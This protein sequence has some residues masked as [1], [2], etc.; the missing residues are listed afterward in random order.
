MSTLKKPIS[1]DDSAALAP[2]FEAVNGRARSFALAT[3][4]MPGIAGNFEKRLENMGVAKKDRVGTIGV[5]SPAGPTANSYKYSAKSTIV[6]M[7]RAATGWRVTSV[8]ACEVRPRESATDYI[9][10][11]DTALAAHIRRQV[12]RAG[13]NSDMWTL[14]RK[15]A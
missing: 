1:V 9:K 7:I 4:Q 11:S 5:Y 13:H 10:L 2:I 15:A 12:I 6:R 3:Y 8:S 14:E